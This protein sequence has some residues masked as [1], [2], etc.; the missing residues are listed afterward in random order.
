MEYEKIDAECDEL[1][2]QIIVLGK[3]SRVY[4]YKITKKV[5]NFK[6]SLLTYPIIGMYQ[7]KFVI[8]RTLEV[9]VP[10]PNVVTG[11]ER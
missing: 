1:E 2:R 10:Y 3:G 6:D 7:L 9:G 8:G 5:K 4:G 11:N